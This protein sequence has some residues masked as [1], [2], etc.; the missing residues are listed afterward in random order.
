L[1]PD[2]PSGMELFVNRGVIRSY[3]I[4]DRYGAN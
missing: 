1:I 3:E 2:D 4:H